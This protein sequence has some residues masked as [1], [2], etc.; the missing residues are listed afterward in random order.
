METDLKAVQ[1]NVYKN[2]YYIQV[3]SYPP[4]YERNYLSFVTKFPHPALLNEI[5]TSLEINPQIYFL[6]RSMHE[7]AR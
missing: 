1:H 6:L 3:S 4:F 2:V 5:S 7:N